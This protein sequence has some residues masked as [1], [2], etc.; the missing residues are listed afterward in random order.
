[1]SLHPHAVPSVPDDTAQIANA[2]FPKGHGYL[3]VRDSFGTFFRDEDFADLYPTHGQPAFAPWRLA[4]VTILQFAESLTDRQAADAVRTRIDWKYVLSLPLCDQGF[5]F[6]VLS[7]FRAR[8]IAGQAEERLLSKL[9][10]QFR[11]TGALRPRSRQRTDATHVLA[12]V[13]NLNW[14]EIVGETM[15]AALN[16]LALIAPDWLRI[17]S[18]PEWLDRYGAQIEFSRL[19]STVPAQTQ[20]AEQVGADGQ[21]LL[22]A[23]DADETMIWL[24]Q[25]PAL[26]TL[27]VVW[28]QRYDLVNG[29]VRFRARAQLPPSAQMIQSPYDPDARFGGK[30]STTWLGYKVHVTETCE[31]DTPHLIVDVQT[32]VATTPDCVPLAAIQASL[33]AR[34]VVPSQQFVDS[35]YISGHALASSSLTYGIDVVGPARWGAH[36][37]QSHT[38]EGFSK[39][40]FVVDWDQKQITCPQGKVSSSWQALQDTQ[41]RAYM[42]ASFRVRDCE[43]CPVHAQCTKARSR[44]VQVLPQADEQALHTAR[45]RQ[46]TPTFQE[47]YACRAGVEGTHS[48]GVRR[49]GLRRSRYIGLTKTHVQHIATA[50]ALNV[51]RA[52]EWLAGATSAQ[53]HQ[54]PLVRLL[55]QAS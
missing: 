26:H 38:Q 17:Q 36:A 39:D 20:W 22:A 48:Q 21:S 53:T 10:E 27:R 1:M 47:Q 33:D 25:V 52:A 16:T 14:L 18:Q 9:I 43:P 6:S 51:I 35:G 19:P 7:E 8:L 30:R 5:D 46:G 37:W 40:H 15:R 34:D 11:N 24:H 4:L 54:S 44:H 49:C 12:A 28:S 45:Q 55:K 42:V 32:T 23:I 41:G 31:P 13:R 2:I 29:E 3:R 50:A